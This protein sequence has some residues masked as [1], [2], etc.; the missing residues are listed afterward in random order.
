MKNKHEYHIRL[1]PLAKYFFG[2]ERYYDE[3]DSVF[4]FERSREY[5]QQTS[6]LGVL[7][8]QLLLESGLMEAA[9]R[10][11]SIAA[12]RLNEAAAL[13]GP[14]SFDGEITTRFGNITYLSPVTIIDEAGQHWV[15]YPKAKQDDEAC[16]DIV[17]QFWPGAKLSLGIGSSPPSSLP[18]FTNFKHKKGIE[19]VLRRWDDQT[20]YLPRNSVFNEDIKN[21]EQI[22]I[23]K[24]YREKGVVAETE[25]RGFYKYQYC[26]LKPG[27]AFSC[28]VGSEEPLPLKKT[29]VR[30]GKERTAFEMEVSETSNPFQNAP[31]VPGSQV[32]L[33]SDAYLP[34]DWSQYCKTAVCNLAPF[35]NLQYDIMK[36]DNNYDQEPNKAKKRLNLLQRGSLLWVADSEADAQGLQALFEAQE[37]FLAIGYNH[38]EVIKNQSI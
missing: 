19:C 37:A 34:G 28:F 14:K 4:Y 1:R 27:L 22:G 24:A 25:D 20:V 8:Y 7:R 32:L 29:I 6:V 18:V 35:K 31:I 30:L 9:E 13:I 15:D 12:N 38:Y 23:Y 5:P 11:A 16:A 2:G 36:A 21:E 33:L 3:E 17:V 26:H 10:G